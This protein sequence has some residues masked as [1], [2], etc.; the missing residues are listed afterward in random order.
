MKK[1]TPDH[2]AADRELWRKVASGVTPLKGRSKAA[3]PAIPKMRSTDIRIQPTEIKAPATKAPIKPLTPHRAAA[4]VHGA[5]AKRL[6]AGELE[7]EGRIDLHGMKR[8]EAETAISRFITF[9]YKQ[10]RRCVLVITG[11]SGILKPATLDWLNEEPLR[12]FI[13][14]VAPARKHGG[15]GAFYVLLKRQR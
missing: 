7:I 11:R 2:T 3:G 10:G 15:D 5:L 14:A 12:P 4:D 9:S 8:A 13:L 1:R 6:R